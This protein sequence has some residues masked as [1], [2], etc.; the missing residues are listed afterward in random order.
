MDTSYINACLCLRFIASESVKLLKRHFQEGS[1]SIIQ[2][3]L[4]VWCLVVGETQS[5]D[6]M[7][8]GLFANIDRMEEIRSP[9]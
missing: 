5:C 6:V 2:H 1:S 4:H 9:Q 3:C 8:D 7:S